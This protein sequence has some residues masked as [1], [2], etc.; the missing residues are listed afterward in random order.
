MV[1][2]KKKKIELFDAVFSGSEGLLTSMKKKTNQ[3][4][5]R[6]LQMNPFAILKS[7]KRS[8]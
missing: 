1:K 7:K 2:Y 5:N 6:V 8:R 4:I 3:E